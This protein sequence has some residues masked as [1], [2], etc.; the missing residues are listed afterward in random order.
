MEKSHINFYSVIQAVLVTVAT[1]ILTSYTTV[2]VV[3]S[4]LENLM[5]RVEILEGRVNL[6]SDR[7]SRMEGSQEAIKHELLKP[8]K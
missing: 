3:E 8:R 6:Q 4:Q 1:A 2:K 5:H 7:V